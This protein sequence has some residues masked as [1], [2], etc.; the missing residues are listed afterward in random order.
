MFYC[1]SIEKNEFLKSYVIGI[2]N[3]TA[4]QNYWHISI[5]NNRVT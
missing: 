4:K 3:S 2:Q 5:D 1:L